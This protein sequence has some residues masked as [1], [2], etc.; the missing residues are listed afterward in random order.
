MR[1]DS[2]NIS[3]S[4]P[5]KTI[6]FFVSENIDIEEAASLLTMARKDRPW[7]DSEAL[8]CA[9]LTDIN[10]RG[11]NLSVP[12]DI[13]IVWD[14]SEDPS[15]LSV[16]SDMIDSKDIV[17]LA[18]AI[19]SGVLSVGFPFILRTSENVNIDILPA[20]N[21]FHPNIT[22]MS[23]TIETDRV[24]YP[25]TINLKILIPN[26]EVFIPANTPLATL[27]PYQRGF[28]DNFSLV[29]ANHIFDEDT[30]YNEGRA[31]DEQIEVIRAF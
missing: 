19:Q 20:I 23:A 8:R 7:T 18:S 31:Y 29:D 25:L 1:N 11:F 10:Q 2:S 14:G 26:Y 3:S 30:V 27:V 13:A 22:V 12:F 24:T 21:Y 4:I 6:A 15:G 16:Q 17:Y 28:S 9:P 5:E